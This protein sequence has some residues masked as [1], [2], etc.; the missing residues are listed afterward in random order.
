MVSNR[1][2]A[3]QQIKLE[4]LEATVQMLQKQVQRLEERLKQ[5]AAVQ[6]LAVPADIMSE[7]FNGQQ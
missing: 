1:K 3:E 7:W 5:P 2:W 6:P 4:Q